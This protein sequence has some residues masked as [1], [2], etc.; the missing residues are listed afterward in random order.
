MPAVRVFWVVCPQELD[1]SRATVISRTGLQGT[2]QVDGIGRAYRLVQRQG[3]HP[4]KDGR[5]SWDSSIRLEKSDP[6]SG[7]VPG[8]NSALHQRPTK[9]MNH[10]GVTPCWAA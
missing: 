6:G 3:S 5:M 4:G 8:A 1:Q 9:G 10:P 7:E 2:A